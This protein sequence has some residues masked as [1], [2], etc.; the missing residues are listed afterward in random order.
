MGHQPPE[1]SREI[2]VPSGEREVAI[3]TVSAGDTWS[4]SAAGEWGARFVRCGPDGYRNFLYDALDFKP[5]APGAARLKL[6]GKF[7]DEPDSAA[8]PIG[9]GCT[10]TFARS[11]E[12]VVFANDRLDGY[13]DNR[14]AVTLTVAP[15]GVAAGPTNAVGGLSGRWR[16]LVDIFNRTAGVSVI[17]AFALGVSGIL[18]F[19]PQGRDLVR[20][21]GE[22]GLGRV[23]IAFALGILFFA[24]QAWSWSRIVIA[25]NYGTDR[26][27]WRPR[28]LLEWGPRV[29]AFLPFA[30]AGLALLISFKWNAPVGLLLLAIGVIF[31]LLVI[32]REPLTKRLVGN[33]ETAPWI[34]GT[35]VIAELAM[36]F[37]AM[38]VAILWP[39]G[40]GVALGGPAIVFFGLGFI[41]PLITIACQLG[42]SLRIPVTGALLLWA[43]LLGM[44][45][46]NHRVG[47]RALI[48]ETGGSTDRPTLES[49]FRLWA[50]GQPVGPNGKRT[51]VLIAVQGGASRAGYWTAVALAQLQTAAAKLTGMDGKPV[52]FSA[53][54]F[55]ISSVSG[56]SVGSVGYSAMLKTAPPN[57]RTP[58][59]VADAET[60]TN[61]LLGFAGRDALGPALTGTLYSDLLYRF[62]PL[63]LL[64]DRAETLERAWEE[65][66]DAPDDRTGVAPRTAGTIRAP[67]LALAPKD[68][69]PWRPLLIVQGASESGGRR[70]LT[71]AVKFTCD[72]VD[73][74]DLLD[75]VGHDVAASTAIL[76]GA[77]FPWVSPGGTFT[78]QPCYAK[79][80]GAKSNDH[81]L[82][83]GYF[84]NAGA[85]TLREMTRA[86]RNLDG[87]AEKDLDI[88]FILIGYANHDPAKPPPAPPTGVKA[89]VSDRIASLIPN[90]VFAPVLGLY[91]GMGAHEA[92][93]AREMKLA[94]QTAIVAPDP[95]V[96]RLTGDNPYAALV[97][98]A[99]DVKLDSG[100]TISYDPPMDWTLSGQAKRYIENSIQAAKPAC[101]ARANAEAISAVVGRLGR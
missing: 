25:S 62:L 96:S 93:L 53:H 45:F 71:S 54:V 73:A 37:G 85:E 97:L 79:D 11:G 36:A 72:E 101:A 64:P 12:L 58:T 8:F 88:V 69:E 46:D 78:H 47:R 30:A 6:M 81:V 16:N 1:T 32:A 55:A 14:G 84:D 65:A 67:F 95:Y 60:L 77:R 17:A 33:T 28:W 80:G 2:Q 34:P 82:D 99:G 50:K 59:N 43:V 57:V 98:C 49:A 31:L 13:A 7:G 74:D 3:G 66:W 44:F 39:A 10:K 83:G 23:A 22:D 42:T 24:V 52:D 41:I 9:A 91:N 92:H 15:G 35:W 56:G 5:R 86:I 19:M 29:L 27:R 26:T 48:A 18:L 40:I 89:W 63:P 51:M 61:D 68:G 94:G 90:D 87:G 76:N 70:M 75:S 21:V 100:R 4:F 20:G 38:V